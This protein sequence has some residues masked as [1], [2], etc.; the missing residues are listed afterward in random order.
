MKLTDF[1]LA[2]LER[3]AVIT[4]PALERVPEGRP[5]WKSWT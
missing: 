4:R 3:E 2:Q 5:D 1:F